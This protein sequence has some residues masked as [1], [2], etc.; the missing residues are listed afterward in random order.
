MCGTLRLDRTTTCASS[1]DSQL[2]LCTHWFE[3]DK[4]PLFC[5]P[6]TRNPIR[7][8]LV[9]LPCPSTSVTLIA[10]IQNTLNRFIEKGHQ[11]HKN[12]ID[13][14]ERKHT[15]IVS[16]DNTGRVTTD[17]LELHTEPPESVS[18]FR[19]KPTTCFHPKLKSR[20][21]DWGLNHEKAQID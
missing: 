2:H 13:F 1:H 18:L 7:L 11:N 14:E 4:A 15:Y 20:S 6:R 19:L 8:S 17:E 5:S 21:F 16:C 12:L 3:S 9:P 10:K